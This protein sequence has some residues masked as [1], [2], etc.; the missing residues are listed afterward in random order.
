MH[1]L[2]IWL[3]LIQ[4][5]LKFSM[6]P[7]KCLIQWLQ[8]IWLVLKRKGVALQAQLDCITT[9]TFRE[10]TLWQEKSVSKPKQ[11]AVYYSAIDWKNWPNIMKA[12]KKV[13]S[14]AENAI[15]L[16][17]YVYKQTNKVVLV[18][19]GTKVCFCVFFLLLSEPI[20][21][22]NHKTQIKQQ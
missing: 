7:T 18:Y 16:A 8:I 9:H 10:Q 3:S 14:Y 2:N 21:M 19:N 20:E 12:G 17:N 15:A 13:G 4:Y 11:S 1:W 5:T 6:G 22:K